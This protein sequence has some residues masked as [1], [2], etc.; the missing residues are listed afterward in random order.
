MATKK[1]GRPSSGGEILVSEGKGERRGEKF[2][3]RNLQL[4]NP[5]WGGGKLEKR[6]RQEDWLRGEH[7]WDSHIIIWGRIQSEH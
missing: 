3:K 1:G 2:C 5:Q 4:E 7:F 6:T